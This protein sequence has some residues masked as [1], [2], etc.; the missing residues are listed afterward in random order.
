MM[1]DKKSLNKILDE[2]V[3]RI[4]SASNTVRIILFGSSVDKKMGINSGIDL[5]VIVPSGFHRRKT[6]QNIYR[7]FIGLGFAADIIVVTK[8]DIKKFKDHPGMVIRPATGKGRVL[9]AA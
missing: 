1:V 9:D 5:L 7:S 3:K 4:L 8:D 6:A 2:A